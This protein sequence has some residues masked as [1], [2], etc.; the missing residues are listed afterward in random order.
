MMK[1]H[2]KRKITGSIDSTG[3]HV[4]CLHSSVETQRRNARTMLEKTIFLMTFG[5]ALYAASSEPASND[6]GPLVKVPR[7]AI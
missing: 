3:K 2:F 5:A 4:L 1:N 6:A 7:S